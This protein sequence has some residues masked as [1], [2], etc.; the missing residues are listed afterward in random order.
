ML[1]PRTKSYLGVIA[2]M[3]GS[4]A[5]AGNYGDPSRGLGVILYF[6]GL[7]LA[8][9]SPPRRSR[10]R[11]AIQT[12]VSTT[13]SAAPPE[14]GV[15]GSNQWRG[16]SRHHDRMRSMRFTES[17]TA[18]QT[19]PSEHR[20]IKERTIDDLFSITCRQHLR[21]LDKGDSVSK[22]WIAAAIERDRKSVV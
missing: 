5:I 4:I 10:E 12:G 21:N 13:A 19:R 18:A 20:S 15:S 14:V 1:L 17:V 6:V 9:L 3:V 7:S 8:L 11:D 2:V 22:S 16:M